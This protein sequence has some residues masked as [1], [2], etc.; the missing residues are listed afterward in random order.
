MVRTPSAPS[1]PEPGTPHVTGVIGAAK[2]LHGKLLSVDCSAPPAATLTILAGSTTW[3]MR[4]ANS[5]KAIVIGADQISC[6]WKNQKVAVN[7]RETGDR[8]A[9]IISL[10][11]Q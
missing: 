9:D 6:D 5:N 8:Q 10:E 11:V 4:A 1:E 7:Y 3:S 2:F